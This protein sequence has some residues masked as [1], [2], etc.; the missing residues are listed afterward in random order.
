MTAKFHESE[1]SNFGVFFS[2]NDR[3]GN[4]HSV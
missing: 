2:Q 1:E 3:T 4:I